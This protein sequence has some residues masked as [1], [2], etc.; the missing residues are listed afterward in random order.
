[1]IVFTVGAVDI[2]E[3]SGKTWDVWSLIAVG[4]PP[5][6]YP[7]QRF[8]LKLRRVVHTSETKKRSWHRYL[9]ESNLGLPRD[10]R[11][12]SPLY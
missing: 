9:G 11:G 8:D 7:Y 12:Y 5:V 2:L 4:D 3:G 6:P 10:K 1:V